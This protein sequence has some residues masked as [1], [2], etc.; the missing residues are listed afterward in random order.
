MQKKI[1]RS[2]AM[3]GV[4]FAAALGIMLNHSSYDIARYSPE[5]EQQQEALERGRL[6]VI[7]PFSYNID[8]D[9]SVVEPPSFAN[10]LRTG[11]I[12]AIFILFA[13]LIMR[14]VAKKNV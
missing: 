10:D 8:F 7:G 4:V 12:D 13:A 1:K 11:I 14:E 2:L 6:N 9:G 5:S 3:T